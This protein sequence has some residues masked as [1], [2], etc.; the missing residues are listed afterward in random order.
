MTKDHALAVCLKEWDRV[1]W[2]IHNRVEYRQRLIQLQIQL[3]AT[4]VALAAAAATY[5]AAKTDPNHHW[6]ALV[7]LVLPSVS[8]LFSILFFEISA[9]DYFRFKAAQYLNR[10]LRHELEKI[11]GSSQIIHWEG[12]LRTDVDHRLA[13]NFSGSLRISDL[14]RQPRFYKWVFRRDAIV[15]D[16]LISVIGQFIPLVAYLLSFLL[17]FDQLLEDLTGLFGPATS[18]AWATVAIEVCSLLIFHVAVG[19][20]VASWEARYRIYQIGTAIA[21]ESDPQAFIDAVRALERRPPAAS[22]EG[23]DGLQA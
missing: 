17:T 5:F 11:A 15:A 8:I 3:L 16:F 2:E 1:A 10:Y 18:A 20:L 6:F 13:G 22:G 7:M 4:F 14:H 23:V 12:H 19:L 21:G 9:Q